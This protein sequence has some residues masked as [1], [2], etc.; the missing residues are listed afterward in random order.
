ME[1]EGLSDARFVD[2][3]GFPVRIIEVRHD[4]D[5]AYVLCEYRGGDGQWHKDEHYVRDNELGAHIPALCRLEDWI[6]SNYNRECKNGTR[7]SG[8]PT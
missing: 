7:F 6:H 2:R 8:R 3:E 1:A 5:C 4:D